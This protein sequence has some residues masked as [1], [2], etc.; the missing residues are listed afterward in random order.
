[1]AV[2]RGHQASAE[3]HAIAHIKP[4]LP[5]AFREADGIEHR[6][7]FRGDHKGN[8]PGRNGIGLTQQLSTGIRRQKRRR[9]GGR[10]NQQ[11]QGSSDDGRDKRL[12]TN[13]SVDSHKKHSGGRFRNGGRSNQKRMIVFGERKEYLFLSS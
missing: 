3:H 13:Q 8:G 2:E 12:A 5:G 10:R 6:P 9:G 4:T 7:A 11:R 1:M